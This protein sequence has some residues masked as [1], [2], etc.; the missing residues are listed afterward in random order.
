MSVNELIINTLKGIIND[1][2]PNKYNGS[3]TKYITFN[4]VD[5]SGTNFADDVPHNEIVSLQIHLFIKNE[6]PR[7]YVKKSRKA[8]FNNGFTYP[9]IAMEQIETDTGYYHTTLECEIDTDTDL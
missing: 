9:S 5:S 4:Y 1:V 2:V 6:N 3:A 8:L 7:P